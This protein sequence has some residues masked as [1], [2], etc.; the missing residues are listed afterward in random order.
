LTNTT[1]RFFYDIRNEL[2]DFAG[3]AL[4]GLLNGATSFTKK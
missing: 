3:G 1:D 4:S 2:A